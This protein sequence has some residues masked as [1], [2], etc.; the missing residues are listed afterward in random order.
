M[1]KLYDADLEK[2][3]N[4]TH[5]IIIDN[6][7]ELWNTQANYPNYHHMDCFYVSE[8][9]SVFSNIIGNNE[10]VK[11][12]YNNKGYKFKVIELEEEC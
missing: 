3:K 2:V 6:T 10:M 11:D 7:W 1:D 8:I 5:K 12:K 9:K 4:G